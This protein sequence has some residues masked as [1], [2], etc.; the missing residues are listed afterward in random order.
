MCIRDRN[1]VGRKEFRYWSCLIYLYVAAEVFSGGL[2]CRILFIGR[3]KVVGCCCREEL[4]VIP[5]GECGRWKGLKGRCK[6]TFLEWSFWFFLKRELKRWDFWSKKGFHGWIL[7]RLY[8]FCLW[9]VLFHRFTSVCG[10]SLGFM[11]RSGLKLSLIHIW[12]CRRYAVCRS[13]WSP[14]H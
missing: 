2:Y 11:G 7:D 6:S 4:L 13:R 5:K 12:R 14:Y 10:S 9:D 1:K 8:G 3:V